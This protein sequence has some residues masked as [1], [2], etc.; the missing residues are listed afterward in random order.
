MIAV[1]LEE[2]SNFLD[3]I[4]KSRD[5]NEKI[6]RR[7]IES[8][9][10]PVIE[11][12][13]EEKAREAVR[14]LKELE[15]IQKLATAKRSSRIADK[16]EKQKAIQEA[17]EAE[18]KRL[19]DLDM[20]HREQE[21]QDKLDAERQSRMMTREQRI[22]EREVRRI[23]Q[24]EQLAK[25]KE[26]LEKLEEEG[27]IQDAER[28]RISE[29][30]LK[31]DMQKRQKELERLQQQEDEWIF[32]CAVCGLHGQNLDDGTHSIACEKCNVWQHSACHGI[33]KEQAERED[34]HFLCRDCKH[35]VENPIPPLKLRFG[36][37]ASPPSA[38]KKSK[39][40]T[41]I[42]MEIPAKLKASRPMKIPNGFN[43][44]SVY[45]QAQGY[46][47]PSAGSNA[48]NGTATGHTLGSPTKSAS[49]LVYPGPPPP[50][51]TLTPHHAY[52]HTSPSPP[53]PSSSGYGSHAMNGH[54][55]ASTPLPHTPGLH[56]R[57]NGA[58]CPS[59]NNTIYTPQSFGSWQ[60]I[61]SF[62]SPYSRQSPPSQ[63][64]NYYQQPP[65]Q[66]NPIP[67]PSY[68]PH[69]PQPPPSSSPASMNGHM[70]YQLLSAPPTLSP[71]QVPPILSPPVKKATPTPTPERPMM[72]TG[73]LDASQRLQQNPQ[74]PP[75]PQQ[76]VS[77]PV[78]AQ[79]MI[80]AVAVDSQIQSPIVSAVTRAAPALNQG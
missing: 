7:R 55:P 79:S 40:K 13:A 58:P 72:L 22:R 42:D 39:G 10:L 60:N 23:L 77:S 80:P 71:T 32:D 75:Q 6:L 28:A 59:F 78:K 67:A 25:E 16:M 51:P 47:S 54:A 69:K 5:D 21:R 30:K 74:P 34:F 52:P 49:P 50:P 14:R 46:R 12:R 11:Q 64:H 70:G 37:S 1:T 17:E 24:E 29:R 8:E 43:M 3:T 76:L 15:N 31:A 66:S 62:H 65:P 45:P 35:R 20:A 9:V 2:Y 48:V 27:R 18:R 26:Q 53:R 61:H 56:Y 36:T 44:S 68:S 63:H 4:R 38:E 57:P 33:T 19:A 41:A 73:E